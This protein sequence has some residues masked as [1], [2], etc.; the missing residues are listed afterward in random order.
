MKSVA[1]LAYGHAR[2]EHTHQA[3]SHTCTALALRRRSMRRNWRAAT[4]TPAMAT[5][6][7]IVPKTIVSFEELDVSSVTRP[8]A[9]DVVTTAADSVVC[10]WPSEGM[11]DVMSIEGLMISKESIESQKFCRL[12]ER[13]VNPNWS[14]KRSYFDCAIYIYIYIYMLDRPRRPK[15]RI[16]Q[17]RW[18]CEN[19]ETW[20]GAH[21]MALSFLL[22]GLS[23]TAASHTSA[24]LSEARP[25][26]LREVR[27]GAKLRP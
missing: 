10:V 11:V 3:S 9:I 5:T 17:M 8:G 27:K 1:T 23:I 19:M 2:K 13:S 24:R 6:R 14:C 25:P 12:Q 21:Y 26:K 22:F 4:I 20:Q 16:S 18:K 7:P 15:L